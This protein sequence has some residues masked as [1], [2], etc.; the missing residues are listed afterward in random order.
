MHVHGDQT[1]VVVDRRSKPSFLR[2]ILRLRRAR[3]RIIDS[4]RNDARL[5]LESDMPHGRFTY[6][7]LHGAR[8]PSVIRRSD[9]MQDG[10]VGNDYKL[11]TEFSGWKGIENQNWDHSQL[12]DVTVSAMEAEDVYRTMK[13]NVMLPEFI[14][15]TSMPHAGVRLNNYGYAGSTI[16][17]IDRTNR[18]IIS[19]GR[20][21]PN[22][23]KEK[24][25]PSKHMTHKLTLKLL[26]CEVKIGGKSC[27]IELVISA[28]VSSKVNGKN[29]L[30]KDVLMQKEPL[31]LEDIFV[32]TIIPLHTSD[33]ITSLRPTGFPVVPIDADLEDDNVEN[34]VTFMPGKSSEVDLKVSTNL[35]I[36]NGEVR[37]TATSLEE[38]NEEF[39]STDQWLNISHES[40]TDFIATSGNPTLRDAFASKST[41][42]ITKGGVEF[43]DVEYVRSTYPGLY[44]R[45]CSAGYRML[46]DEMQQS[47]YNIPTSEH[48]IMLMFE[49]LIEGS[50][51]TKGIGGPSIG[52]SEEI[53]SFTESFGGTKKIDAKLLLARITLS[54][55]LIVGI[56][57]EN[58]NPMSHRN[59]PK[60]N[61]LMNYKR[62][63]AMLVPLSVVKSGLI[64]YYL[65]GSVGD[66][67]KHVFDSALDPNGFIAKMKGRSMRRSSKD[68]SIHD[69]FSSG[70][71]KIR[72]PVFLCDEEYLS[73]SGL[74]RKLRIVSPSGMEFDV[75]P[76]CS[77]I[78]NRMASALRLDSATI[79]WHPLFTIVTGMTIKNDD[80]MKFEV[81][82]M[83]A[84]RPSSL[85]K[86]Y[87]DVTGV[88]VGTNVY[89][90]VYSSYAN[91]QADEGFDAT[92]S[93]YLDRLL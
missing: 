26:N 34:C 55:L 84:K 24:G 68:F 21:I 40:I 43:G 67:F 83:P 4:L 71:F 28:N 19:G 88:V 6:R 78:C 90:N 93:R 13:L 14:D 39:R 8:F 31:M 2:E 7:T 77:E 75:T 62:A 76:I 57:N 52:H 65:N 50:N 32:I 18:A 80:E 10:S 48:E 47:G 91:L 66:L 69:M 5:R 63:Q 54:R 89:D 81:I 49:E 33:G 42:Q 61:H 53:R 25:N 79:C 36:R 56:G 44:Q 38:A 27:I 1:G 20:S 86:S 59:L 37:V 64:I 35:S 72:S 74:G 3:D 58:H 12:D 23:S 87:H 16:K 30:L 11:I 51:N 82:V 15:L 70:A 41:M 85:A 17:F 92:L 46:L 45:L 29:V 22:T 9:V 60:T 73:T